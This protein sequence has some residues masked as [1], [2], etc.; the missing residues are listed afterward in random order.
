MPIRKLNPSQIGEVAEEKLI[1]DIRKEV[2]FLTYKIDDLIKKSY[3]SGRSEK[4]IS[5]LSIRPSIDKILEEIKKNYEEADWH[6][7]IRGIKNLFYGC[8]LSYEIILT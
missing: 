5:H 2:L 1:E 7:E 3:E 4:I 6:V 8:I